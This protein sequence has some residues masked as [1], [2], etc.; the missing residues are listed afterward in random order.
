MELAGCFQFRGALRTSAQMLFY[1]VTSVVFELVIDV[2]HNV[3]FYPIT[4]HLRTP[5]S[6]ELRA[7]SF[8]LAGL[9]AARSPRLAALEDS[10]SLFSLISSPTAR[11]AVFAWRGIAYFSRFLRWCSAFRPLSA[12]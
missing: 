3:V 5:L 1:F 10:S 4:F 11:C 12:T 7:T 8:E 2:E 9:P 6:S